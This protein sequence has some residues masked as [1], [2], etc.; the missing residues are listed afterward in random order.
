MKTIH[1]TRVSLGGAKALTRDGLMGNYQEVEAW[2]SLYP[3]AG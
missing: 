3:A 2:D 1:L